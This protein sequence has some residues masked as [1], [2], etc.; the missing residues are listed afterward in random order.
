[1]AVYLHIQHIYLYSY[2]YLLMHRTLCPV[3]QPAK[4]KH[5]PVHAQEFIAPPGFQVERV[6]AIDLLNDY[7]DDIM[8][9][10]RDDHY[11]FILQESGHSSI[12]LDFNMV[13][14]HGATLFY[15]LPGQVH[16]YIAIRNVAG[17]FM[18]MDAS[19]LKDAFRDE[20]VSIATSQQVLTLTDAGYISQCFNLLYNL[21]KQDSAGPY[22]IQV[23]HSILAGL[24]GMFAEAYCLAGKASSNQPNRV[25]SITKQFKQ[26]LA[27]NFT[28]VK[29]PA[30]Y[31]GM[32]NISLSYLNEVVKQCTGFPVTYWVQQQVMLEARRLLYYTSLSVKEI[33]YCLGYEDHTYFARL[34]KKILQCTPLDFR[35]Q[36][37]E[38]SNHSRP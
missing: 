8:Q 30:E 34:F 17:W 10:H 25:E 21:L 18:A 7:G 13:E 35:K 37:R 23:M 33:A 2:Y 6:D 16:H 28:T 15:I 12:M 9:A 11:I 5:I 19:L 20:L 29:S 38:L 24:T 3:A 4:I 27:K 22:H 26:L 32:L 31:A 36:Y 1:M 14:L